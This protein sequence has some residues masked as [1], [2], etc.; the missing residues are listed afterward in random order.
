M[1]DE[2]D[3]SNYRAVSLYQSFFRKPFVQYVTISEL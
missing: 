1:N 2:S 3:I